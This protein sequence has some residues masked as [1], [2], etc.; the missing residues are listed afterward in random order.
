MIAPDEVITAFYHASNQ[1]D[2]VAVSQLYLPQGWH[3]EAALG[4]CKTGQQAVR[5]GLSAFFRLL[6]DAQ[7]QINARVNSADNV[8]VFYR[9]LGHAVQAEQPAKP[10]VIE[11][12]HLFILSPEG[13]IGVRDYW[14]LAQFKQQMAA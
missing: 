11:G 8:L 12:V 9:L 10:L 6:P 2:A 7:W 14:D 13:I 5:Q 1:H 3:E 4:K